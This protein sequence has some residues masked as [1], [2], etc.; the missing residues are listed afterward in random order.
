MTANNH[1][2]S[3]KE[4]IVPNC[5]GFWFV[6]KA[7]SPVHIGIFA[8]GCNAVDGPKDKQDTMIISFRGPYFTNPQKRLLTTK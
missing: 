8:G 7:H 5:D 6:L 4:I 3:R 2:G 1:L